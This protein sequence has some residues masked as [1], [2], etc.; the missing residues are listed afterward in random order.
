M[1]YTYGVNALALYSLWA[2]FCER[3]GSRGYCY[4]AYSR[5]EERYFEPHRAYHTLDHI[6]QSLVEFDSVRHLAKNPD[7]VEMAI[8]FHDAVYDTRAID[9]EERSAELVKQVCFELGL[10]DEFAERTARL[11]LSSKHHRGN[12][13]DLDEQIFTDIDLSAWGKPWEE[14]QKDT[15]KVRQ[16]YSWVPEDIFR[17]RRSEIL[18]EFMRRKRI[19]NTDYFYQKYET[20]AQENLKRA[21]A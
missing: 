8:W 11:V 13:A 9:N 6:A 10:S 2:E 16:E 15:A 18:E 20:Q 17:K 21:I 19:Y 12:P 14:F 1:E 3:V 4:G 7:A 5:L